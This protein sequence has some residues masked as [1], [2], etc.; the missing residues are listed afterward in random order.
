M[1]KHESEI[2][3]FGTS[4]SSDFHHLHFAPRAKFIDRAAAAPSSSSQRPQA[5]STPC[6][7]HPLPPTPTSIVLQRQGPPRPKAYRSRNRYEAWSQC[8]TLHLSR[9]TEQL[10][11]TSSSHLN[12]FI[13][14]QILVSASTSASSQSVKCSPLAVDLRIAREGL[15][16]RTQ[17]PGTPDDGSLSDSSLNKPPTSHDQSFS[18][19]PPS[20][21]PPPPP[22][23]RIPPPIPQQ[24]RIPPDPHSARTDPLVSDTNGLTFKASKDSLIR[25]GVGEK[26]TLDDASSRSCQQ[27]E[28]LQ[29]VAEEK[30][31]LEMEYVRKDGDALLAALN[32]R[33][34]P[35][36]QEVRQPP[37]E[38]SAR[39]DMFSS[40]PDE[41]IVKIF[42]NNF[43]L[44]TLYKFRHLH[45][46]EDTRE[47]DFFFF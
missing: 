15:R 3:K 47:E 24:I 20:R 28:R 5:R 18:P 6:F 33:R 23:S 31:F 2:A 17:V 39:R 40:L 35:D 37:P 10:I 9:Y 21:R 27:V 13:L 4:P 43:K 41:E 38:V 45:G 25:D 42:K 30:A 26:R 36:T 44:M 8:T 29:Q 16:I 1:T 22:P 14:G 34:E 12:H 11:V 19:A 46:F 32:T 7:A